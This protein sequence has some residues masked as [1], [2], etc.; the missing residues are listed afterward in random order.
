MTDSGSPAG[1]PGFFISVPVYTLRQ[2]LTSLEDPRGLTRTLGE[3]D[4]CRDARGRLLY[5]VGNSAAVFRFRDGGRLRSLRCY[6][7]PGRRL[8]EI[9]GER[10][11]PKELYLYLSPECGEWVDV[12]TGDWTEGVTLREAVD[13]AADAGDRSRLRTLSEAF[14]RLAARLVA[15][16]WAHGDLKPENIVVTPAGELRLIDFDA[17]FLPAFAGERSAELGTA[18]YQHPARTAEDFDA[19]IDDYPAALIA[20]ALHA[21]ALDPTFARRFENP[22]GLLFSPQKIGSDPALRAAL[23]L[24]EREGRAAEYRIARLLLSPA[25]RLADLAELLAFA[26][27]HGGPRRRED[28]ATV[29]AAGKRSA[30]RPEG[31]PEAEASGRTG[32]REEEP[33]QNDAPKAEISGGFPGRTKESGMTSQPPERTPRHAPDDGPYPELFVRYGLWGFRSAGT[34]VVPPLYDCGFDFT[35]GLA[36]VRLGATWH[37]IDP[38]GYTRLSCPGC[39]A[40][41]PFREGRARILEHGRWRTIGREEVE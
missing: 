17:V 14:D 11:H 12:V 40:V 39:Q 10:H 24:F 32:S 38:E 6:T 37:F 13:A 23:G 15:D 18:A 5:S 8:A 29:P 36:A 19:S 22:D 1:S 7:R 28:A 41:K 21:L 2:Y 31:A 20:T 35:E 33:R 30:K 25:L 27:T 34:A 16:D 4:L 26:A 9:Y 3:I